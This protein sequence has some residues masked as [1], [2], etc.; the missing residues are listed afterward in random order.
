MIVDGGVVC[1]IGRSARAQAPEGEQKSKNVFH[2][3][4]GALAFRVRDLRTEFHACL[5]LLRS[6][7]GFSSKRKSTCSLARS[8]ELSP[9]DARCGH[10][11]CISNS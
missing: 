8:E 10:V 11:L 5:V 7:Y 9:K 6:S 2:L 1:T 3:P 4:S